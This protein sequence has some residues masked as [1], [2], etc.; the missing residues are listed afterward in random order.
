MSVGKGS[1]AGKP[2]CP[3]SPRQPPGLGAHQTQYFRCQGSCLPDPGAQQVTRWW[4]SG[5][6]VNRCPSRSFATWGCGFR[7]LLKDR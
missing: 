6:T 7:L 5:V 3:R 1:Q 2:L 4:V